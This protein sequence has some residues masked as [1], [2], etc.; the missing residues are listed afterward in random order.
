MM[1]VGYEVY[2]ADVGRGLARSMW[3]F[4]KRAGGVVILRKLLYLQRIRCFG[5]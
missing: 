2:S 3:P 5:V 4:R 1:D